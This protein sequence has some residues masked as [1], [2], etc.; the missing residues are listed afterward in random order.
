MSGCPLCASRDAPAL[1]RD[2]RLWVI[3]AGEPDY[4]GFVRVIWSAHI[5]E[6]TDLKPDERDYCMRVVFAAEQA[7]R[8]SLR[9]DKINVACLGNQVAHI[10]WHVIP[11]FADDAHFPDPVWATRRRA[12]IAHPFD[13]ALFRA[14]LSRVLDG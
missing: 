12:G 9:P 10:H 11:R 3:S 8:D 13:V 5:R 14:R 2:D 1:W 4:P 6:M 7:L